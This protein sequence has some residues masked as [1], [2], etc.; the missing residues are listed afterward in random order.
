L[1]DYVF[2]DNK[3]YSFIDRKCSEIKQSS[4]P[5]RSLNG[6]LNIDVLTTQTKKEWSFNFEIDS[7]H[8]QRLRNLWSKNSNY[9]MVDWDGISSY[10]IVC[11]N[12]SFEENF[13]GKDGDTYWFSV[14]LDFKEI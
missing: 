1:N 9:I 4:S 11:T 14:G 8:L 12:Q 13:I 6:T 7:L 2:I 10:T 5:S 3:I